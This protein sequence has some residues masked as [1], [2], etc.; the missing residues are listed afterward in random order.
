MSQFPVKSI[1]LINIVASPRSSLSSLSNLA[2]VTKEAWLW[3]LWTVRWQRHSLDSLEQ[4]S[5]N[6]PFTDVPLC[7]RITHHVVGDGWKY[8]DGDDAVGDE[9]TKDLRQEVDRCS[10]IAARVLVTATDMKKKKTLLRHMN[11]NS[12]VCA[13]V[14]LKYQAY[15]PQYVLFVNK[16]AWKKHSNNNL[17]IVQTSVIYLAKTWC[18][19]D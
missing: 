3:W 5:W 19:A 4:L 14:V 7:V 1:C 18:T 10:V 8:K 12:H 2:T 6:S 11:T 13:T 15:N 17:L 16:T 9:V